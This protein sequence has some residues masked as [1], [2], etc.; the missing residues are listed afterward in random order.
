MV[1]YLFGKG[2][3]SALTIDH[4]EGWAQLSH[5]GEENSN[6]SDVALAGHRCVSL[7]FNAK[8]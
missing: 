3:V 5:L 4:D 6:G 7:L 1:G 2:K 8:N